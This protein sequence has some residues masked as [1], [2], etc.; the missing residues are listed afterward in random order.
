MP[1][2]GA[3][4]TFPWAPE[5]PGPALGELPEWEG[6]LQIT[7]RME[8]SA[9]FR[10]WRADWDEARNREVFGPQAGRKEYG[11]NYSLE[12]TLRGEV[13]AQT[14][15]VMDLKELRDLLE[16]EVGQRFDHRNLNEDTPYFQN[17]APTAENLARVV[18]DLLDE[19][20]PARL[21]KSVRL[22]PTE[23]LWVEVQR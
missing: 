9:S 17:R 14:G 16:R 4:G 18:F 10:L 12:V 11:H 1:S 6:I 8:F 22:A 15:M 19:A 2:A 21:L 13:D 20:L 23:D 5:I 7:R 3:R